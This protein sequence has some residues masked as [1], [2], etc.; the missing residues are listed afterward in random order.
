MPRKPETAS[1][2]S[3]L[4]DIALK[5]L[6]DGDAEELLNAL[7]T[8]RVLS[9]R[10]RAGLLEELSA[11]GQM[12]EASM[13]VLPVDLYP[14]YPCRGIHVIEATLRGWSG[15]RIEAQLKVHHQTQTSIK[16]QAVAA[17]VRQNQATMG[18]LYTP[19]P[20]APY[21]SERRPPWKRS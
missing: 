4:R 13:V 10:A 2:L 5:L 7:D 15:R 9:L 6:V 12:P 18:G 20:T 8:V 19:L 3:T 16:R 14:D 21:H 1:Q 17:M 11:V